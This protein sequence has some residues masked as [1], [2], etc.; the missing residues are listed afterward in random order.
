MKNSSDL[1]FKTSVSSRPNNTAFAS[2]LN[3][4]NTVVISAV[5]LMGFCP[6]TIDNHN[7]LTFSWF[8]FPVFMAGFHTIGSLLTIFT[9]HFLSKPSSG[10][11]NENKVD[12]IGN[13]LL[14]LSSICIGSYLRM[15]EILYRRRTVE[16]WEKLNSQLSQIYQNGSN[17]A[18]IYFQ[19]QLN[20]YKRRML[21]VYTFV[22]IFPTIFFLLSVF[23]TWK[24]EMETFGVV[25]SLGLLLLSIQLI[26]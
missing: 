21:K 17:G 24:A 7:R 5:Q 20:G 13:S 15:I 4:I 8:S 16:V 9:A 2:L 18:Q 10:T 14:I 26:F 19:N 11:E 6:F 25:Y 3:Q 12:R 1:I 23:T 22:G